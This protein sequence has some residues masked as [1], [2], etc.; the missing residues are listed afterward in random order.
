[1]NNTLE[2]IKNIIIKKGIKLSVAE[3]CTGGLLSSSLTDLNGASKFIE[4]NFVTYAIEAKIRFLHVPR[5]VIEDF[6][7]V[8]YETA[9]YMALGLLSYSGISISTT[10]YLGPTGGDEINPVGTV[11]FGF[12]YKDK[13][14]VSRYVSDKKERVEIKKDMVSHIFE[15]FLD[16]LIRN[17]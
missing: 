6:G 14:E 15:K 4:I 3:S 12:A 13:V 11:Y 17:L 1:M 7:V 2:E 16:F 8:S 10:G 9:H 5:K